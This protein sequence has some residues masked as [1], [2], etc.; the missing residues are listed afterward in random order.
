MHQRIKQARYKRSSSKLSH[1]SLIESDLLREF[2]FCI[3]QKNNI[4]ECKATIPTLPKVKPISMWREK[5]VDLDIAKALLV[6]NLDDQSA[7]PFSRKTD[8]SWKVAAGANVAY[9]QFPSQF[10]V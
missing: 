2:S 1:D 6:G 10:Q 9:D 3:L 5:P 8:F 4:Y 7:L